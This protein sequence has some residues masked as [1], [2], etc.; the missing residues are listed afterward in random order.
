MNRINNEVQQN[1]N[2]N[3]EMCE[4]I[5]INLSFNDTSVVVPTNRKMEETALLLASQDNNLEVLAMLINKGANV[6]VADDV[7]YCGAMYGV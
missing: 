5:F 2:R 6:N 4:S 7:S 3:M 1:E